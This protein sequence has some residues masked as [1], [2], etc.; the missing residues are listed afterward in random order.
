MI[1]AV[2]GSAELAMSSQVSCPLILKD[3][4]EKTAGCAQ[5]IAS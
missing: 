2:R 1:V 4:L 5:G 3:T